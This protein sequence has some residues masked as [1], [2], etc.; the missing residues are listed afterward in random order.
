[1]RE[2]LPYPPPH[3][4]WNPTLTVT[5]SASPELALATLVDAL[6]R[7]RYQVLQRGSGGA[8]LRIGSFWREHVSDSLGLS[9]T[10]ILPT[11]AF[12]ATVDLEILDT[13]PPT[14][15]QVRMHKGEEPELALAHLLRAVE[16]ALQVLRA[17]DQHAEAG[18]IGEGPR[19]ERPGRSRWRR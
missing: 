3:Y 18:E 1:M 15:L 12:R 8:E 2:K 5:T 6:V 13:A 11:W 16:A 14:Q 17:A 10:P 7:A 9:I 19:R 4:Y